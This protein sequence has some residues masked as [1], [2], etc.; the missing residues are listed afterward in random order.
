VTGAA[1]PW[2][3]YTCVIPTL[4]PISP[5]GMADLKQTARTGAQEYPD[6]KEH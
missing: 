6:G 5:S 2:S 3:S 4:V 1:V